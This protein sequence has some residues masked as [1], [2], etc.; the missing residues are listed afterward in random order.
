[1]SAAVTDISNDQLERVQRGAEGAWFAGRL[2]GQDI[3]WHGS[4]NCKRGHNWLTVPNQVPAGPVPQLE[5]ILL[6]PI[7]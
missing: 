5:Q 7:A 4:A 3:F 6:H 2:A 1:M